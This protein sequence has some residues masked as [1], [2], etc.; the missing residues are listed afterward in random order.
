MKSLFAIAAFVAQSQPASPQWGGPGDHPWGWGMMGSGWGMFMMI[1]MFLLWALIIVGI[2][3]LICYLIHAP[4][5][6]TSEDALDI[7]KRR[8]AQGE[9]EKSGFEEKRK[10]LA[11]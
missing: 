11:S 9:I 10:D 1:F 8:Y 6:V 7:L 3:F 4:H 5:A 2:V